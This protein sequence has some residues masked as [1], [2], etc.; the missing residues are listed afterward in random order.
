MGVNKTRFKTL[1]KLAK[2]P[3]VIEIWD[4][5]SDGLWAQLADGF[6]FEGEVTCVHEWSCKDLISSMS[7][8]VDM[9][10]EKGKNAY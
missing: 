5:G 7:M 1:D 4:E 3:R 2:D 8:V 6:K 10:N 9:R